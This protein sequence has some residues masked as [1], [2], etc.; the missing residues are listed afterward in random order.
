MPTP[1]TDKTLLVRVD[2]IGDLVV[3]L[4]ADSHPALANSDCTW[5]ISQG[6]GWVIDHAEP[7][8][9]YI[10][11]SK[12]FSWTHFFYLVKTIKNLAPK[13]A[14]VFQAPWF[15]GFA[16]FW[17]RVPIRIGRRS[18]WHSY[19]FFNKGIR[20][21]RSQAQ[22]HESRYN[23]E[24][25][26]KGLKFNGKE[27]WINPE[28][29]P[30]DAKKELRLLGLR[31]GSYCVVHPGMMGSALNWPQTHYISLIRELSNHVTVVITGTE[32]DQ[33]WLN[34][35][36]NELEE[37]KHLY[38]LDTLLTGTE[39]IAVLSGAQF[40]VAPSTGIVHIA[41]AL[42]TPI[43]GLYSPRDSEK[44]A[45]WGPL[46]KK[47][48]VFSPQVTYE[49]NPDCMATITVQKVFN[50]IQERYLSEQN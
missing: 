12:K 13:R 7:S 11:I 37:Q 48:V 50:S 26:S 44:S 8:K 49:E 34:P 35:I 18:Q 25:I 1:S 4:N 38:W 27:S 6:L 39:L 21:K 5:L 23:W 9:N 20:Q 10:E 43:F 22:Q 36:R 47:A 16:I 42:K 3:S 33:H 24:L 31:A 2:K 14:V 30:K 29:S 40:V 17:A 32:S 28:F 19:L 41:A 45:R 15:V 46:S